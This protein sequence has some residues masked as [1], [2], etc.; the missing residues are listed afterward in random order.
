M[1]H[2]KPE[3]ENKLPRLDF[4]G[5]HNYETNSN[6][7]RHGQLEP[8][9]RT[10]TL[11]HNYSQ[12]KIPKAYI[13]LVSFMLIILTFQWCLYSF[14]FKFSSKLNFLN[15]SLQKPQ[16]IIS[17]Q[18]Y[19]HNPPTLPTS[20]YTRHIKSQQLPKRQKPTLAPLPREVKYALMKVNLFDREENS[21][22]HYSPYFSKFSGIDGGRM[23]N[24]YKN[25]RSQ[26]NFGTSSAFK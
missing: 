26:L 19:P 9:P 7:Q 14:P 21:G 25:E 8:L 20:P 6:V 4:R 5:R 1:R 18:K 13:D 16:P 2:E 23:K 24:K 15:Q 3:L 10:R 22:V 17:H 12:H 11:N